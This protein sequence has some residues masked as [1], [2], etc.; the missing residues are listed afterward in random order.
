MPLHTDDPGKR[1]TQLADG[2]LAKADTNWG[3]VKGWLGK[4]VGVFLT[5]ASASKGAT[6]AITHASVI[7]AAIVIALGA[8][9]SAFW[10]IDVAP[11]FLVTRQPDHAN[12]PAA[13]HAP[14][15]VAPEHALPLREGG[16]CG[17]EFVGTGHERANVGEGKRK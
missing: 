14:E 2:L 6:L 16:E 15:C 7:R 17:I 5:Q 11:L 10:R 1:A 12:R 8:G 9:P 4:R 3:E 13:Q